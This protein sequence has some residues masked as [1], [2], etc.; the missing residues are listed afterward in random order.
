MKEQSFRFESTLHKLYRGCVG[1]F[2][3][4]LCPPLCVLTFK[5]IEH[6][7]E[8]LVGGKPSHK[9]GWISFIFTSREQ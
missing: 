8:G 2:C 7:R 4:Y 3:L 5:V 9:F 1:S 6:V